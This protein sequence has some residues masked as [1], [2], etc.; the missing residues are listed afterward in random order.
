MRLIRAGLT[1]VCLHTSKRLLS[2]KLPL[3][4]SFQTSRIFSQDEQQNVPT[5]KKMKV[6]YVF[7]PPMKYEL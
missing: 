3:Y 6:T 4:R 7:E 5:G 1:R 2:T